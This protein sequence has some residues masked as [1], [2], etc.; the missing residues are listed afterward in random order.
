[1]TI[2]GFT[3]SRNS[4]KYC[5]PIKESIQSILPVVDEFMVALGDCDKDDKTRQEI[6]SIGSSKIKIIDTVWDIEGFPDNTVYAQQT[7]VAKNACKGEWLFYLQNDEIVHERDHQLIRSAFE[8]Y[9]DN[10]EIEGLLFEYKHFWGDYDHY[11]HAHSW[12]PRE[13]RI[14][15]N[16]SDIHSWK[17]AQSFRRF[18]QFDS[19][20][21]N[22]NKK[23]HSH[24]LRVASIGAAIF[25]YGWVRPPEV[26]TNKARIGNP[27]LAQK[28]FKGDRPSLPDLFDFGPLDRLA[29]YQG[30]HPQVMSEL[31]NKCNWKEQLQYSGKRNFNRPLYKHE[32][33][34]YRFLS[35]LE[36]TF[37]N[38]RQVG[39][40][41]NYE[42]VDRANS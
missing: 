20:S 30:T 40:F 8:R 21:H 19:A 38:G 29:V 39:G 4:Q 31:I 27:A 13:I 5:F 12:Y 2:S 14:I 34:K 18:T 37:F 26:M 11:H 7:D 16:K 33:L 3:F 32:R 9:R 42:I 23:R 25:H 17:D 36:Y 15:K 24:K 22:Y 1:M 41:R 6:E 10:V 28:D 35:W